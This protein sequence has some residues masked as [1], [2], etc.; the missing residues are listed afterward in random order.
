MHA[1]AGLSYLYLLLTGLAF[2]TPA[3]YWIAIALGGGFLTRAVHP[4]AGVVFTAAV[5]WM[6]RVW[7][8]DMR[9]TDADRA[10]RRAIGAYV[11]NEDHRVPHAGRFNFGQKAFFWVMVW[12]TLV[13]LLSGLALWVPHRIPGD[14]RAIREA[15]VLLHASSALVSIGAFIVHVYMG[16]AVVP[17]GASA[18]LHGDVTEEWA[19]EHHPIW[20]EELAAR[21]P[22]APHVPQA[23]G[24]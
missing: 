18:I 22:G 21:A 3:L 7:R 12:A 6:F 8:R 19:R 4:W 10:W 17:G 5:V 16:L 13:L 1:A 9:T 2:W 15:A 23:R 14:L 24:R 20:V 11:R